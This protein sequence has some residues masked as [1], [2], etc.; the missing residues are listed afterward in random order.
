MCIRDS[1]CVCLLT[2]HRASVNAVKF[3][4][5]ATKLVS[6]SSDKSFKVYDII[7]SLIH[8]FIGGN[9]ETVSTFPMKT[10]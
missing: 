1:K 9:V 4:P 8:I 5:D 2:D 3:S 6:C 10:I 7:L